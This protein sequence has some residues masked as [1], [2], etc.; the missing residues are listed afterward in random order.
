MSDNCMAERDIIFGRISDERERQDVEW[1]G[2]E[3][4]DQHIATDWCQYI[5]KQRRLA[6]DADTPQEFMARMIKI[7]ALAVAA[8]EST[9]RRST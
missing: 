3:H 6:R 9:Q 2:L 5:D 7:A 8:I 1:G 4:D